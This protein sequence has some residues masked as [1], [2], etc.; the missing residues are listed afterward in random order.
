LHDLAGLVGG[1]WVAYLPGLGGVDV[2]VALP[3]ND[4]A[5][6]AERVRQV[7][8]ERAGEYVYSTDDRPLEQVVLDLLAERNWM[9]AVAESCTG[10]L[11]G[12]R[13]TDMA[14]SS[15]AFAGGVICYSNDAKI[16]LCGVRPDTLQAHG[17]VSGEVARELAQGVAKRFGVACGIGVTGIAGPDG[18]TPDKPVGTVHVALD[19]GG[20]GRAVRLDWPG[21]RDLVRRRAVAVALDLLRR[22]LLTP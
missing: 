9:L 4:G 1:A 2:R 6:V 15:R 19:D 13:V 11:L 21:D 14:G 20:P 16:A 22:R 18:G 5:A 7:V 12:G 3:A 10:G 17:A 8:L